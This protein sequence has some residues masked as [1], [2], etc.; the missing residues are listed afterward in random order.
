MIRAGVS[1]A[2]VDL[3]TDAAYGETVS[4][5]IHSARRSLLASVFIV[6]PS[7]QRDPELV[8]EDL[9]WRLRASVWRGVDVRLVIGGSQSNLNL[10]ALAHSAL[11]L[12]TEFGIHCRCLTRTPLRGSHAKFVIADD[13]VLTGSHNWSPGAFK[14]QAQDSVLVRS[15]ALAAFL[16]AMFEEQWQRAGSA[17][18]LNARD[19]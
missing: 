18:P 2:L 6:D 7:P 17:A 11:T 13:L 3:V 14:G 5:L 19:A 15:S 16:A 4:S 8:V 12:A 10:A 9:F 1:G